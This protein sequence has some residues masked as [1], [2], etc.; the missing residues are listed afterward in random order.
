MNYSMI[1]YVLLKVVELT[2]ALMTLP[3]MVAAVYG[4][5]KDAEMFAVLVIC[6][7]LIGFIGGK[8]FRPVNRVFFFFFWIELTAL[9]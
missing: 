4:E 7:F 5:W 1:R 3:M 9:S 2:G 6:C 8:I